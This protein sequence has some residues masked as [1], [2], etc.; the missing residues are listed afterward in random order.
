MSMPSIYDHEIASYRAALAALEIP[1]EG[2]PNLTH[3]SLVYSNRL[4]L[5][6][7]GLCSL[8][9]ARLFELAECQRSRIK[10]DDLKGQG[11]ARL[12]LFLSRVDAVDFGR[13]AEWRRFM[14]LY[15]VRNSLVHSYGG[16]VLESQTRKLREALRQ[17]KFDNALVGDRRIRLCSSHLDQS[18]GIVEAVIRG[19]D[20]AQGVLR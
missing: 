18:V 20:A 11:V 1:G 12:K 4:N 13:I 5:M 7:I 14:S 16:L 6:L 17:L 15:K 9:E 19:I 3:A 8:V 10:L 2:T